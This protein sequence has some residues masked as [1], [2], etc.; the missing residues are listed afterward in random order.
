MADLEQCLP[1]FYYKLKA[2]MQR[3]KKYLKYTT[4]TLA[5]GT[6][7]GVTGQP[8]NITRKQSNKPTHK[9]KRHMQANKV[10]V[11]KGS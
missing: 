10:P 6:A 8:V 3:G 5:W 7:L 11:H 9:Q 2:G 1:A 4:V